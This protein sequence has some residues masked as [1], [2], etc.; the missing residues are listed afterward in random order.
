VRPEQANA[1]EICRRTLETDAVEVTLLKAIDF[2]TANLPGRAGPLATEAASPHLPSAEN[3]QIKEIACR[4]PVRMTQET[5]NN[6]GPIAL[7]NLTAHDLTIQQTTGDLHAFGP[8]RLESTRLGSAT[9]LAPRSTAR[10]TASP[11]P[12]AEGPIYIRVDYQ[13]KI[14]GN[15]NRKELVFHEEIRGVYG[16]VTRWSEKL[17]PDA[18]QYGEKEIRFRCDELHVRQVPGVQPKTSAVEL[19]A[20]GN[21]D[22]DGQVFSARAHRLTY[23]EGKEQLLF[24]GDGRTAAEL[25]HQRYV[26]GPRSHAR[27][28]KLEYWTETGRVNVR[29]AQFVDVGQALRPSDRP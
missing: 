23:V 11:S 14:T 9:P 1:L 6:K 22:V 26:G 10:R 21:T 25:Y 18:M 20:V 29:D 4:G 17:D 19:E 5:S 7:E 12:T 16:P 15:V 8:G 13:D 24:E 27:A 3:V 2:A 28:G